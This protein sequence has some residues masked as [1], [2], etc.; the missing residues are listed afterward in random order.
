MTQS[1]SS[2]G[3]L[4]ARQTT[5]TLTVEHLL[6]AA[7]LLAALGIRFIG[8]ADAPL[9]PAE[10]AT[11]W[12]AWL[13]ATQTTVAGAPAPASALLYGLQSLLF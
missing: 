1:I 13:A 10:S 6:Y 7:I 4:P 2:A 3:P 12:P 9:S 11:A 5:Q 8:L